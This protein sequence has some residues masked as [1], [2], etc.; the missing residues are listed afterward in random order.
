MPHEPL[1]NANLPI[2]AGLGAF[3]AP[4]VSTVFSTH[5]RWTFHY[6]TSA[7]MQ[8][9]NI[10]VLILVFRFRRQEGNVSTTLPH[11]PPFRPCTD[12]GLA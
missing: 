6:L 2:C 10:A 8:L 1:Q 12:D 7:G 9:T 3:L 11:Y 4:F 5:P